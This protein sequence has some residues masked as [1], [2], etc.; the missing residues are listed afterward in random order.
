MISHHK[1]DLPNQSSSNFASQT[2]SKPESHWDQTAMEESPIP[3]HRTFSK[4]IDNLTQDSTDAELDDN[5]ND[6][7]ELGGRKI[8]LKNYWTKVR[9]TSTANGLDEEME[10]HQLVDLDTEGDPDDFDNGNDIS[11]PSM[12]SS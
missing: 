8:D 9:A 10:L 2:M 3:Q 7:N 12:Y 6:D 1:V 4:I 5:D 11:H